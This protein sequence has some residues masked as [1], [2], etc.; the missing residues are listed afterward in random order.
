M[1]MGDEAVRW[2]DVC[3]TDD[4]A[5]ED[6]A[7][8]DHDGRTYAVYRTLDDRYF[9]TDGLCTHG[10]AHLAEG[11]LEDT[12]IECPKHNGTFDIVTGAA[13]RAPACAALATYRVKAEGGRV[14]IGLGCAP[15]A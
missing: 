15:V 13:K 1:T 7:R 8:F 14:L 2:V 4:I 9:A 10:Q 3:G 12:L 6:V 11:Y 5:A